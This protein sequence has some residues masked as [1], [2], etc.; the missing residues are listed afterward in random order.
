MAVDKSIYKIFKRGSKTYFYSS[1]FFPEP[2]KSD[3]FILY[4]FVRKADDFV[5]EIPQ[6]ADEFYRFWEAYKAA[7]AGTKSNDLVINLFL[8]LLHRRSFDPEWV[9]AFMNS[10]EMDL[11]KN[12][13]NTIEETKEYMY[14]SA[15]V[16]GLFMSRIMGLPD[17]SLPYAQM[18]G[19][20]MQYIN[21]IRDIDEDNSLG[22]TYLPLKGTN[23]FSLKREETESKREEFVGFIRDQIDLYRGWQKEA[24]KGY[25]YIRKRYLIPIKTASDM[26]GWTAGQIYRD[27]FLVYKRKMK[28]RIP[29]IIGAIIGNSITL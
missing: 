18:Q 13:Y 27:P 2:M 4:S 9:N 29:R 20:S 12:T 6:R 28:P 5:D 14:G 21:F 19:R 15:E 24:S 3:V 22:R 25:E 8:D 7:L 17:E 16:I 10:M 11:E 1:I 26:Y 23:L